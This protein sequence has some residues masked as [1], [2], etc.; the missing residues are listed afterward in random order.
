VGG[1]AG[2]SGRRAAVTTSHAASS[3]RASKPERIEAAKTQAQQ[4]HH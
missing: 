1:R 3:H 4:N 2:V